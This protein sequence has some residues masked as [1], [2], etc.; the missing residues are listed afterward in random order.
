M[1]VKISSDI[2]LPMPRSVMSSPSHMMTPVPAIM[3][4]IIMM[5]VRTERSLMMSYWHDWKSWPLRARE[6]VVVACRMPRKIVR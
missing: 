6:I 2:P 4:T 3:T 5:N 1:D